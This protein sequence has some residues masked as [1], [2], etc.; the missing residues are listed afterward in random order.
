MAERD[1]G[2]DTKYIDEGL[3]PGE[4]GLCPRSGEYDQRAAFGLAPVDVASNDVKVRQAL[5]TKFG[6]RSPK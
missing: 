5:D 2:P 3:N 1:G 6:L 4:T